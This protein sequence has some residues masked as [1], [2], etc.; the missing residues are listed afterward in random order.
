MQALPVDGN[1]GGEDVGSISQGVSLAELDAEGY[2]ALFDFSPD[3]VLFTSPDG[4]ILAA[5]PAACEIFGRTEEELRAIGRQGLADVSD[6]RWAAMLQQRES[7]GHGHAIARMIRGDGSTIELEITSRLFTDAL[8]QGRTCTVIRDV[9]ERVRIE[10]ELRDS[11][12]RLSEAERVAQIGSWEW[13]L[14]TNRT[15]WSEGL[16]HLY[17]LTREQFDPSFEG[18]L[19][20]VFPDDREAV[21]AGIMTAVAQRSSFSLEFRALRADGRVRTLRSQGDAV[22]NEA[23]EVVRV[24]GVAQDITQMLPGLDIGSANGRQ[25]G[26]PIPLTPRQLE[27]VQ[28]IADGLTNGAIGARLVVSEGTVK[29]HVKQILAKTGSANRTEAVARLLGETRSQM[30]SRPGL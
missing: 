22:V 10:T 27:I 24:V 25:P 9:T 29:W 6:E 4:P 16:F 15:A 17:G 7:T 23:G 28:L 20:R 12:A 3:G 30:G 26:G 11:R 2:R 13:D 19:R 8:G 5:N 14:L 21:R 18:G 1:A